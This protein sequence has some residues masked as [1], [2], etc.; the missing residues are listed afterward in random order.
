MDWSGPNAA[1][2]AT[3]AVHFAATLMTAGVVVFRMA[4]ARAVS[5]PEE[6]VAKLFRKWSRRVLWAGLL[7]AAA[8]GV[9]WLLLQASSMSG[10]PFGEAMTAEV[11]STVLK[12]TQFGQVTEI[13][14]GLA[15]VLAACLASDR[16]AGAEW[17]ALA[18]ALALAGSIAWTGHAGSTLGAAGDFHLAADVLHL[19][20]A[21]AWVGGLLALILFFAAARRM[22]PDAWVPLARDATE[23]FSRLGVASVA[24]LLLTGAVNATILVGSIRALLVTEYG[25]VLMLKLAI[26][27]GMLGFAAVNRFRFTPRL[28]LSSDDAARTGALHQLTRNSA[29][30]IALGLII[31]AIVGVLGTMHPAIHLVN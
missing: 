27:A 16:L 31:L 1:L 21:A 2:I 23:R 26:F 29:L 10:L 5:R 28:A 4:V 17:L 8:T 30:E 14:C 13:R 20:A 25:R 3:R 9:L 24:A 19:C 15:I 22:A 12:E 11:L 7:V 18:S 6:G